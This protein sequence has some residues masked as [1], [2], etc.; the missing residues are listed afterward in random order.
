M[1]PFVAYV[2]KYLVLSD[3]IKILAFRDSIIIV[4]QTAVDRLK[5]IGG[6][7]YGH[8]CIHR[9]KGS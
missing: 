8:F 1:F 4:F 3:S 5:W 7:Y 6:P 9:L 2:K